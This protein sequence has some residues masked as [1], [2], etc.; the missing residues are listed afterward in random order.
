ML[1]A[2]NANEISYDSDMSVMPNPLTP[3][4]VT[5]PNIKNA[6]FEGDCLEVLSRFPDASVDMVLCDLPY[7]TTQNK[8]DSVIDLD[9][10]WKAYHRVVK[11]D[12]AIVLTSQG[13]FTAK[14]MMS[15]ERY[16]KYKLAWEKSKSTNFLNAKK[17]PLRKHEDVCIFYRKQPTYNPQMGEGVA[18]D[19]GVRKDQLSGSYGDFKPRHVKSDGERY[20]TDVIYFKTAESEGTVW[21]PTQKPVDLGRYLIRTYTKPGDLVLDNSFGSGS[22]LVAAALEGRNFCGIE[23]NEDVHL[24]KKDAIDY[25]DVA[26]QRLLSIV[27]PENIHIHRVPE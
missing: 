21:H 3:A 7:G 5:K 2:L 9:K 15:N 6:L 19:K 12:G 8:W 20:P 25:I 13:I 4:I 22:F 11:P 26:H 1:D 14:L 18:Y 27:S 17:Q 23:K 10:L 16:F 24:F